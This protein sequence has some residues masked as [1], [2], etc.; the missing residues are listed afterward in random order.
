MSRRPSVN[1]NMRVSGW[2]TSAYGHPAFVDRR[3]AAVAVVQNASS[4]A[5][6]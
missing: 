2:V 6:A 1:R 5:S 4:A 3:L